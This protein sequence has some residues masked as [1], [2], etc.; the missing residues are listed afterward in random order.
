MKKMILFAAALLTAGA[1]AAPQTTVLTVAN[2]DS[3]ATAGDFVH[4]E[5]TPAGQKVATEFYKIISENEIAKNAAGLQKLAR[6][7]EKFSGGQIANRET[8]AMGWLARQLACKPEQRKF[9]HELEEAYFRFFTENNCDKLK[10]YLIAQYKL[11]G[12]ETMEPEKLMNNLNLLQNALIYNSPLRPRWEPVARILELCNIKSGDSIV[13]YGC[14]QGYYS[15][16]FR[17]KVGSRG[18]VFSLDNDRGH[19]DFLQKFI[20]QY[21]IPNML[22]TKSTD[23][24][25]GMV[26]NKADVI[27][28]NQMYH[29]IY[30]YAPRNEQRQLLTS[31]RKTLRKGG[32]LIVIGNNPI[33]GIAGYS[34]HPDLVIAQL[35]YYDFEL[36]KQ[37]QLS[38]AVYFLEFVNNKE[39]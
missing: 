36:K 31:M 34:L 27:F 4:T 5:I 8:I 11:A 13:D 19:I 20:V 6:E 2:R 38:P 30:I 3:L 24:S 7:C 23:A 10:T 14:R 29:F 17:E 33:K 9:A 21:D 22:A 28:I 32:R 1:Y 15:Q 26:S 12:Y 25:L 37:L 16:L 39:K 35:K 18:M